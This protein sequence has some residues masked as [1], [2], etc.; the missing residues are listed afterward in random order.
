MNYKDTLNYLFS[1]LPMYQRSGAAAYKKDIGNIIKACKILKNPHDKFKSIHIAG[2]NGK[3]STAHMIASVLQEAGFKTGLYTSP[4]LQ[5]FRERIKINGQMISKDEVV[6]FVQENEL[7]FTK[8]KMSFFEYTVA[9][10]FNYFEK[11]KIDIA[12]IEVG[13]GGRLDSTNIITPEVSVIT[14]ISHDHTNL[15]GNTLEK[16]AKEKAGIIKEKIPVI[17]GRNQPKINAIFK[18][19]SKK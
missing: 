13:L 18:D 8:I 3:G 5:D 12:I 4:H 6:N 1:Q 7:L 19:F 2:T 14:N 17:I 16:I 11:S 9:M 10:A 15:L